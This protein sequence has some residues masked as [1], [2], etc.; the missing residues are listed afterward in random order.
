[1]LYN[2]CRE[3]W[4]FVEILHIEHNRLH[5]WIASR[6]RV[7]HF[8]AS[9]CENHLVSELVK[10]LSQSASDARATPGDEHRISCH[11]HGCRSFPT[12]A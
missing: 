9:A 4:N 7:Q 8:L 1:M 2:P 10:R 12:A 3:L 5:S 11:V 6:H